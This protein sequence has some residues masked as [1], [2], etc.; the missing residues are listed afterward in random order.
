MSTWT[1]GLKKTI[2]FVYY[3]QNDKI[4]SVQKNKK[5]SP[6]KSQKLYSKKTL[7]LVREQTQFYNFCIGITK[8]YDENGKLT[9][10]INCDEKYR[11]TINQLIEK[12]KKDYKVD[13]STRK[14]SGRG[15]E[16]NYINGKDCYNVRINLG[17]SAKSGTKNIVIDGNNGEVISESNHQYNDENDERI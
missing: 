17:T 14:G 5:D 15:I 4:I 6:Y 3:T 2:N 12:L 7:L 11:F 9:G 13:F 1:K 10:T 16:R 8:I